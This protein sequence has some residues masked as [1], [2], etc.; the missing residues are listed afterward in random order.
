MQIQN[1][2][3]IIEKLIEK[4]DIIKY[5]LDTVHKQGY[6]SLYSGIISSIFGSVVQ[7]GTYFFMTKLTIYVL[8]YLKIKIHPLVQSMLINF[9]AAVFTAT[10]T[11]PIWVLNA[12]MAKK[13]IY[14]KYFIEIVN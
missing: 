8:D 2:K 4:V 13:N 14:V 5:A 11:N 12:R 7:N 3:Q 10:I 6:S 9:I 1:K